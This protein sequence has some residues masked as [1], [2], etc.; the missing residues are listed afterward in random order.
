VWESVDHPNGGHWVGCR[1]ADKLES[2]YLFV[3]GKGGVKKG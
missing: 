1:D 2:E 3:C